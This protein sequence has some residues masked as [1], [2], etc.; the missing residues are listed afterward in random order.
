MIDLPETPT[1]GDA[2][3]R[4]VEEDFER[5]RDGLPPDLR[6]HLIE[7]HGVDVAGE[8]AGRT[9]R[10]PFGKASGQLS[11]NARQVQRDA[12]GQLGFVVLKTVIAEDAEGGQSMSA[13][14]I[15]ETRMRVER[16]TAPTGREGW[17]V[18]WKGRGWSDTLAAYCDFVRQ[19]AA[20]GDKVG[21]VTAPSVKY[22]LP[23]PGEGEFRVG[24]Y[25]HTT[26]LLQT[27]W[28]EGRDAPMPLEKDFSP[29]L[30]GDDRSREQEQILT[31]L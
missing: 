15:P 16:I 29:T 19:A 12:D 26:A 28:R 22:H 3:R 5:L 6:G 8:Y 1:L 31:W 14:A 30:A 13:W 23:A 10:N 17:T 2:E 7:M 21:M 24:E 18:T 11:L 4:R 9:I 25:Q 20:I 27:A